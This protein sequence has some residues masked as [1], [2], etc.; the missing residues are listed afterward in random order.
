MHWLFTFSFYSVAGAIV[1]ASLIWKYDRKGL[2]R[3][4]EAHQT[5]EDRS[6][7]A[8]DL[9]IIRPLAEAVVLFVEYFWST[10]SGTEKFTK[11]VECIV[12]AL[13]QQGIVSNPSIVRAEVQRAYA[14]AKVNGTLAASD[15]SS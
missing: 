4:Y 1:V 12:I 10:L 11:A 15:G 8:Q 6:A 2:N 7:I 13:G 3:F 14:Q 9:A 5:V